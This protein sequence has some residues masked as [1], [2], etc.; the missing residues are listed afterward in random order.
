M[1]TVIKAI[2]SLALFASI[3]LAESP[4]KLVKDGN[5]AYAKE[6]YGKAIE[7][8]EKAQEAQ[9]EDSGHISFNKANSL[10]RQGKLD[11]AIEYYRDASNNSENEK[12]TSMAQFNLGNCFYNKAVEAEKED[13]EKAV[14]D[15]RQSAR[16]Y[17]KAL[18][19]NKSDKQAAE[20]I[21][22]SRR[23]IK[24][25]KE[26]LKQ[27]EQQQQGQD[28]KDNKDNKDQEQNQDQQ[29]QQGQ[30]SDNGEKQQQNKD[31]QQSDQQQGDQSKED[32]S[33]QS[34]QQ[35]GQE[36]EPK[37]QQQTQQQ[38]GPQEEQTDEQ[39]AQQA[40][41]GD[42]E[43][44]GEPMQEIKK[45]IELDPRAAKIIEQEKKRREQVL[46]LLKAKQKP[47]EKDW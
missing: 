31:Q 44:D 11:D 6:H 38:Q 21:S 12:L 27:Q 33:Q 36:E 29:Q 8:Y 23:K 10:F 20:N 2:F 22:L 5:E 45:K 25:L 47:V 42:E 17:R 3:S 34:Q 39:K 37:D 41:A 24:Q 16:C 32:D 4:S 26:L 46:K 14:E 19:L 30:N 7:M 35:Q 18:D 9:K 15:Y 40:Q 1:N 43:K 28:N 13:P